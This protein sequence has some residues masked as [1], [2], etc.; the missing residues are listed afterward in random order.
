MTTMKA[1]YGIVNALDRPS[2]C[3]CC[4][5]TKTKRHE[6]DIE[7]VDKR[8]RIYLNVMCSEC[9]AVYSE[10][11][12]EQLDGHIDVSTGELDEYDHFGTDV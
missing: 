7:I 5:S 9:M 10:T 3:P 4:G 12:S 6:A 11:I 2:V 1:L 8:V